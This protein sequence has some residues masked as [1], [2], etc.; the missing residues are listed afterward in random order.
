M[1]RVKSL[2]EFFILKRHQKHLRQQDLARQLGVAPSYI[3]SIESGRRVPKS[4]VFWEKLNAALELDVEEQHAL[5]QILRSSNSSLTIPPD[6]HPE[7][8]E[9]LFDLVDFGNQLSQ[10]QLDIIKIAAKPRAQF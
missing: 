5:H 10:D 3:S 4:E 8:R 2:S 6:I 7:I 9:L 1:Q